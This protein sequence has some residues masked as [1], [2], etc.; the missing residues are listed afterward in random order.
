[1]GQIF[2]G[3]YA[4]II[5]LGGAL[6][7]LPI[8]PAH[9]FLWLLQLIVSELGVFLAIPLIFMSLA[10]A[11][12]RSGFSIVAVLAPIALV[13]AILPVLETVSQERNW[14]WDLEYG[15][16]RDEKPDLKRQSPYAGELN[17]PLFEFKNLFQLP[18][19]PLAIREEFTTSDGAKL[20]V[21]VYVNPDAPGATPRPWVMSIH[22]GGWSNGDPQDLD[23][24]IPALLQA[25]YNVVAPSYR[26]APTYTWP[27][28]EEDVEA[29]YEY[30][31]KNATRFFLDPKQ[32]W[33][34]GRSAGG[35]IALKI[36]YASKNVQ[37][38]KGVIALYTPT[39]LDFGYRWAFETD[40]L[41]SRQLLK[42]FVGTTPDL[43]AAKYRSASP[44]ADVTPAAPP[45]L[46]IGGRPDPL[47][48]YRHADRLADR[49]K[50]NHARVVQIELPWATHG[51]D[52][53]PNSPGGQIATN[54]MLRFMESP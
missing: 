37:G 4:G 13:L 28:Q 20:P 38:V 46:L 33:L 24:T 10:A 26:F 42:D 47:V 16:G 18:S 29:A 17:R 34:L 40:V 39:D 31:M 21:Y 1:M 23:Q 53:F 45:T 19:H 48:W 43:D 5:L 44:L 3:I 27:R 52:F 54:A 49:L 22:G 6:R 12:A 14:L 9:R 7:F 2:G 11:A 15:A 50:A 32:L 41:G 51:F 36:A 30:V 25:G 8:F 35:Q